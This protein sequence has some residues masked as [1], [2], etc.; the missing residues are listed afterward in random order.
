MNAI[1]RLDNEVNRLNLEILDLEQEMRSLMDIA[2]PYGVSS[3][4]SLD[5]TN[6]RSG[7]IV[8]IFGLL[9]FGMM[10]GLYITAYIQE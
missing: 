1:Y 3:N 2:M 10:I 5:E 8:L 9:K 4:Q 7:G 6:A